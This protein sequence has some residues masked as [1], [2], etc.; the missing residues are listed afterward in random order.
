MKGEWKG[1]K[2]RAELTHIQVYF[3]RQIESG[4]PG[5]GLISFQSENKMEVSLVHW[6]ISRGKTH[7]QKRKMTGALCSIRRIISSHA[8]HI[9]SRGR[10]AV[11]KVLLPTK[12]IV[13][14]STKLQCAPARTHTPTTP[15]TLSPSPHTHR[16][17]RTHAC[18]HT[19]H[20]PLSFLLSGSEER[21]LATTTLKLHP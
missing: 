10:C 2:L 18:T 9:L 15:H 20:P 12:E 5:S 14:R 1:R 6:F 7:P 13:G 4:F 3:E 17:T 8:C 16:H 11:L 19:P 21:L